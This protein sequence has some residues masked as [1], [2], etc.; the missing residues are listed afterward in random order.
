[1]HEL[2][3]SKTD[4]I[5]RT[6][7]MRIRPSDITVHW[8]WPTTTF[9]CWR[10]WQPWRHPKHLI[11]DTASFKWPDIYGIVVRNA[12]KIIHVDNLNLSYTWIISIHQTRFQ[13]PRL[14][15][16]IMFFQYIKREQ[17]P[18]RE[19]NESFNNNAKYWVG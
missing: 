14:R 2:L 19:T 1:M 11:V 10:H 9:G 5:K 3:M 7:I 13:L 6:S 16:R 8:P 17:W 18:I 4:K 15:Y 12:C